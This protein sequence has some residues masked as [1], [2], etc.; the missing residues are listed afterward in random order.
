MSERK[1]LMHRSVEIRLSLRKGLLGAIVTGVVLVSPM[2]TALGQQENQPAPASIGAD[3][4]LVYFGPAPSSV[5]RELIGPH[6]LLTAGQVDTNAGTVTL[7][8]YQGRM[9]SGEKVWYILT[10][11]ND[12]GNADALGLN[13]SAKLTYA[14]VGRGARTATLEGAGN[15]VFE[16]GRVDFGPQRQVTPGNAPNAYPPKAA[17]PGS[18][19]D[20][21]YS[22]LVRIQNA[23]GAIY[24]APIIAFNVEASQIEFPNGSPDYR[25][26]HDKVVKI[27][28]KAGTVTLALTT[29]FSFARPVL[30]LSMEANEATLAALEGVTFAPAIS[31]VAVG[32]DDGAFSAVER[33]F[34][35]TNGPT[36]SD[37]PQ[38]QG[39]NSALTDGRGPLNI[40]GGIPTV[41]TDYSP[42]WDANVGEW[43]ADAIQKGYRS[44]LIDE[45]EILGFVERGF[46]TGPGG[47]PYGSTGQIINCPIVTRFL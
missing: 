46:L 30:Y 39:L 43:T 26:V 15:L 1:S 29:G 31:D 22:P 8:L 12:K 20:P 10:D 2:V 40:L 6:Q 19:G 45:F 11:T 35:F 14:A 3:V 32:R 27:S 41:A 4:P 37:N 16:S 34:I 9:R 38:R 23:G 24:N 5:Q 21:N 7:P 18:V 36:G 44:R 28:P 17:Q 25:L 42:L 33:I 13:F 47:R